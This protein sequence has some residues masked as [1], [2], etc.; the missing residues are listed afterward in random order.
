MLDNTVSRSDGHPAELTQVRFRKIYQQGALVN[1]LNP[2]AAV[3]FSPFYRNLFL[4]R[5]RVNRPPSLIHTT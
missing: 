5:V 1:I 2:K 4:H 3:F